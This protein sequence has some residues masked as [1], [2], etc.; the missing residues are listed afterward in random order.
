MKIEIKTLAGSQKEIYTEVPQN[1]ME[2]YIEKATNEISKANAFDGFRKGKAPKNIVVHNIGMEKIFAEA[3]QK[4]M[5]DA[6]QKAVKDNRLIPIGHPQA[7]IKKA[8]PGNEL[9]FTLTMAILPDVKLGDYKK[10]KGKAVS[11]KTENADVDNEL[12]TLQKKRAKYIT[13]NEAASI[14]D[15][16]EVDFESR[17]N[18]AK[19]EG[20]ESKN[21]PVLIGNGMFVPGFEENLIG[22]KQGEEK[23]FSLVFP[24]EY[25]KKDLAE[26]NVN[27]KVAMKIVQK[28]ELPEL[29][30]DFAKSIGK[31][32]DL[33]NL[34]RS[35]KEGIDMEANLK[36]KEENRKELLKQIVNTSATEIPEILVEAEKDN[37]V[38]DLENNVTHMGM[39]FDMY[40]KN[41]NT[42][43]D[44]LKS[45]WTSQAK[46]KVKAN[47]VISEIAKCEK[48]S[49]SDE[50]IEIKMNE[51][52]KY[53]P[54]EDE[55][56]K[57][58]DLDKFKNYIA[59]T[60]INEKVFQVLE[61][62]GEDNSK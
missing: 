16:V 32:A 21:H 30:D 56:R 61:K 28:V 44:K 43:I 25:Y 24:K 54:N 36:A 7:S 47:L 22:M 10:V 37:M 39:D 35:I 50:E 51:T 34:K 18:G 3:V 9:V 5:D 62:I 49:A 29:N 26:K 45:E 40:L 41:V 17:L 55:I 4:A 14:G 53:Y 60:I 38:H 1:E 58:I 27:F 2:K 23:E 59:G 13:K 52:L 48:I 12:K 6:Y 11:K 20:G 8:A 31:F 19:L 33:E 42:T 15:R 57:K 46:D